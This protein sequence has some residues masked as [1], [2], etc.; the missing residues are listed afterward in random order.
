MEFSL[1]LIRI[2]YHKPLSVMK[3]KLL[4][5]SMFF[6]VFGTLKAQIP[7]Q[8]DS[9]Y[10][11]C[12]QTLDFAFA[13]AIRLNSKLSG[14]YLPR[15]ITVNG[16]SLVTASDWT[17]GFFPGELWYLSNYKNDLTMQNI[18]KQYTQLLQAQQ[19]T[20][21][22]HDLG[23]MLNCSYG[24]GLKFAN[25][26]G[27][28]DVLVQSAKSLQTRINSTVGC[29]KSWNNAK[30]T[31]PV[32]IDNMM[33]L[34]IMCLATHLTGDSIYYKAA[35]NHALKTIT[36][37]YRVD[38]SS[39]H[40]VD[41]NTTNGTVIGKQTVQG[42]SNESSW[43]RGQAWG[44]YGF[45]MMYNETKDIRFL[46][47][48][49]HIADYVIQNLPADFVFYWD[50][51]DPAIPN[52]P[53]DASAASITASALLELYRL[54]SDV[55]YLTKAEKIIWNL[56]SPAYMNV[57][58]ENQN[59]LLKHCTGHKPN[60]SEIDV[61]IIYADYYFVEAL[62]RYVKLKNEIAGIE[63]IKQESTVFLENGTNRL[64]INDFKAGII[65]IELF[66][67]SGKML[68]SIIGNKTIN[69]IAE[70]GGIPHGLYIIKILDENRKVIH[71]KVFK[72]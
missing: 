66:D 3:Y 62:Y 19:Y 60:N 48:A 29:M 42:Y 2:S 24:N 72:N 63:D 13:Q 52:A 55:L 53:R 39:F 26:A 35:V 41:Y 40:L 51:K 70:I 38:Y 43:A 25:V 44:L 4:F 54:T 18:A 22:T 67:I 36:N 46:N 33:N 71:F 17:S 9:M 31:Y 6:F 5:C 69:Q 61:P 10:V 49:K 21:T 56:S 8:N 30:W 45:T 65:N 27:Y 37:H 59:F 57:A 23:F 16:L 47:H 15:T 1:K 50:Y 20:T 12:T 68:N 34:E 64:V 14:A 58:G 28:Q 11:R 32:I 7:F